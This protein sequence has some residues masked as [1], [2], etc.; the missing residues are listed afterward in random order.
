LLETPEYRALHGQ[1]CL[2]DQLSAIAAKGICDQWQSYVDEVGEKETDGEGAPGTEPGGENEDVGTTVARIRSTQRAVEQ[3]QDDVDTAKDCAAGLGLGGDGS[4]VDSQSLAR[5][6]ARVKNDDT[7]RKILA[8]AGRMRK[9]CKSLQSHKTHA[10]RGEITGIE[11]GGDVSRLIP[12]ELAMVSGAVPD[13]E[14]YS[15]YRLAQRRCLC[16]KNSK[17]EQQQSGPIVVCVD[18][19][20]SM[21]GDKVVAAKGLAMAMAW[22]ASYQKRWIALVGYSGGDAGTR[23]VLPPGHNQQDAL[24]EWL[25]HFYGRGSD[26][27]VPLNELPGIYWDE[28]VATGMPRGKTDVVMITDA[29]VWCPDHVTDKYRA[30]AKAEKVKTYGIVIGGHPAGDLAKVCDRHWEMPAIALET[31]AVESVLSI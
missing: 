1:T 20:G 30:W 10:V 17:N 9:R 8:M 29:V 16:Y 12:S 7:L 26:L 27:D 4:R 13:L 31:D 25:L 23:L 6:F 28:F 15:L 21:D 3:A 22:L 5:Y 19:S 18:E 11:L 2:D 24:I 14:M